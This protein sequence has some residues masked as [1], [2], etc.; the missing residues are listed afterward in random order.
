M[1][2]RVNPERPRFARGGCGSPTGVGA[3]AGGKWAQKGDGDESLYG[4]VLRSLYCSKIRGPKETFPVLKASD[5][6]RMYRQA[7]V[8]SGEVIWTELFT[9]IRYIFS[10]GFQGP[11]RLVYKQR[12]GK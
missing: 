4:K 1:A 7:I 10:G 11:Q 8:L 3:G 2:F 9:V 12:H 6:I 5:V